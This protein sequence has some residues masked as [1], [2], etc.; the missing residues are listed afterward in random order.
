M[1]FPSEKL[2]QL[3]AAF[4]MDLLFLSRRIFLG[5]GGQEG[6]IHGGIIVDTEGIIRRGKY[7]FLYYFL[8]FFKEAYIE[9]SIV[10]LKWSVGHENYFI[11]CQF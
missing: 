2:T 11:N 5:D 1:S 9:D 3:V 6:L 7:W 10:T 8:Y 4:R